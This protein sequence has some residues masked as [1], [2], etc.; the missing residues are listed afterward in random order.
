MLEI[1]LLPTLNAVISVKSKKLLLVGVDLLIKGK[2]PVED[3]LAQY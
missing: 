1:A 3:G 2:C